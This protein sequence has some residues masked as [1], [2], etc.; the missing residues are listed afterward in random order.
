MRQRSNWFPLLVEIAHKLGVASV[1]MVLV[2]FALALAYL[3]GCALFNAI[4]Y[5]KQAASAEAQPISTDYTIKVPLDGREYVAL[6]YVGGELMCVEKPDAQGI[7]VQALEGS[8]RCVQFTSHDGATY[9]FLCNQ[10]SFMV[11]YR[12]DAGELDK[13][14]VPVGAELELGGGVQ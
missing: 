2:V 6:V 13:A 3:T 5:P 8:L 1:L 9:N 14:L 10:D 12:P 4:V 7:T 11:E